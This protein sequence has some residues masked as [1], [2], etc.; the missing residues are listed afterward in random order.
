M[1]FIVFTFEWIS[2]SLCDSSYFLGFFFAM[3]FIGTISMATDISYMSGVDVREPRVEEV[4]SEV[5]STNAY[6]TIIVAR[7]ARAAKLV[8]RAGRLSR[9]LKLIRFLPFVAAAA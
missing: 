3:D 1:V 6:Q 7:A 5:K 2:R 9:L 8:A 4:G